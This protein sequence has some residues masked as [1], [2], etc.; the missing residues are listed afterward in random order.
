MTRI[1]ATSK[2]QIASDCNR[3]SKKSLPRPSY[4][5]KNSPAPKKTLR[6]PSPT[7]SPPPAS[8]P[9]PP[10]KCFPT[11]HPQPPQLPTPKV[12]TLPILC[13]FGYKVGTTWASKVGTN[14]AQSGHTL[15]AILLGK[16]KVNMFLIMQNTFAHVWLTGLELFR[17]PPTWLQV[18]LSLKQFL[19]QDA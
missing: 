9:Q 6:G 3:N 14:W 10:Q 13:P 19:A 15:G 17:W 7:P 4:D 8:P 1:A 11:S 12:V 18:L 16:F 2:S 5:P